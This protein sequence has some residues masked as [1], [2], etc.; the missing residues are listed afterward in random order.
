LDLLSILV[1]VI[2]SQNG[3]SNNKNSKRIAG[4]TGMHHEDHAELSL[5]CRE[6]NRKRYY[7]EMTE[8]VDLIHDLKFITCLP[9]YWEFGYGYVIERI[10]RKNIHF[11]RHQILHYHGPPPIVC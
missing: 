8:L 9:N 5:I 7:Y 10:I 1:V 4:G 6:S 3:A 11:H 2:S